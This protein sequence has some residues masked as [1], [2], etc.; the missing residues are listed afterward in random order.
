MVVIR[1]LVE[2][3][4]VRERIDRVEE[5]PEEPRDRT[6]DQTLLASTMTT[7]PT[8][9]TQLPSHP[10]L[11]SPLHLEEEDQ[12]VTREQATSRT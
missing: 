1:A 2:E 7:A 8:I 9:E 3:D 12:L 5:E 10:S 11:L 6:T 4:K